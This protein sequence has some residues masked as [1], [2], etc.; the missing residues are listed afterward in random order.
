MLS[1]DAFE[2][3]YDVF[4]LIED[5]AKGIIVFD[6]VAK[7]DGKLGFLPLKV[8]LLLLL[9]KSQFL[10]FDLILYSIEFDLFFSFFW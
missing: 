8:L 7:F 6:T 2:V 4:Y 3:I 10:C 9:F 5:L 1:I